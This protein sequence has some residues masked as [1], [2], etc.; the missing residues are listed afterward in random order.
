MPIMSRLILSLCLSFCLLLQLGSY[1]PLSASADVSSPYR[2]S[3]SAVAHIQR[4]YIAA[5]P[6]TDAT[7]NAQAQAAQGIPGVDSVP[8]FNGHFYLTG[9]N[10][11]GN[12]QSEWYTNTV[13]RYPTTAER[14]RLAR[15]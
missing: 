12:L 10:S 15:R 7:V 1:A 11:S 2:L 8:T 13:G 14:P 6:D 4:T 9:Y 3:P 5:E